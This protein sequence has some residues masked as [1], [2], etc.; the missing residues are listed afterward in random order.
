[1]YSI[2][3]EKTDSD[4]EGYNVGYVKE[5]Y[6]LQTYARALGNRDICAGLKSV[7]KKNIQTFVLKSRK[8]LQSPASE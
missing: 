8:K 5:N 4:L 7:H 2:D 1:M 6:R 3:P